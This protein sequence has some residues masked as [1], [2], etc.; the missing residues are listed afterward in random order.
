MSAKTTEA[1]VTANRPTINE[2]LGEAPPTTDEGVIAT[3]RGILEAWAYA[4]AD[5][6]AELV[7]QHLEQRERHEQYQPDQQ[8]V[9]AFSSA[10]E[11]LDRSWRGYVART[12]RAA[13]PI[14]S[15]A[16]ESYLGPDIAMFVEGSLEKFWKARYEVF[17]EHCRATGVYERIGAERAAAKPR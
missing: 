10:I 7:L 16:I 13:A 8:L 14:V 1:A 15:H 2:I 5:A 4:A 12:D 9:A 11:T 17:D 3:Y 6:L